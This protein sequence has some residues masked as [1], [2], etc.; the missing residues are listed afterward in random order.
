MPALHPAQRLP[1]FDETTGRINWEEGSI[2]LI[3]AWLRSYWKKL[4]A[5]VHH[6]LL[7]QFNIR[8]SIC[9]ER[10]DSDDA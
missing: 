10:D 3:L 6:L 9:C 4:T 2:N 7:L 5:G 8:A 1:L